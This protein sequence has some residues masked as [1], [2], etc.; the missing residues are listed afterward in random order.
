MA[1]KLKKFICKKCG[2][3]FE[4]R[5]T[6]AKFCSDC[7][8]N[9]QKSKT[10]EFDKL[11]SELVLTEKAIKCNY[12]ETTFFDKIDSKRQ[13]CSDKC[14]S[15]SVGKKLTKR[16]T[17]KFKLQKI[18][19]NCNKP[20]LT[21]NKDSIFCGSKCSVEYSHNNRIHTEKSI[22]CKNC[23][24][25]FLTT[26][27]QEYC[28]IFCWNTSEQHALNHGINSKRIRYN[29]IVFRST[30]E[31]IVAETLDNANF[32]YE[33]EQHKFFISEKLGNYIPDFYI[34]EKDVYIE[35]KGQ[36]LFNAI[37][38]IVEFRKKYP[39]KKLY[40]IDSID[41]FSIMMMLQYLYG[42]SHYDFNSKDENYIES[43][44]KYTCMLLIDEIIEILRE[45]NY[46]D[47]K[48][49]KPID[50]QHLIEEIADGFIF[51]MN[52]LHLMKVDA[53]EFIHLFKQK[54]T[55]NRYRMLFRKT[56]FKSI[57]SFS[58]D[59]KQLKNEN[60]D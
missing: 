26:K 57:A 14:E 29:N 1:Y 60:I 9:R 20:F 19:K 33:Y 39:E 32:R 56:K 59:I 52:L 43:K 12:C 55:L 41:H 10:L 34:P 21:T 35:V 31:A 40:I 3:P 36:W 50:R 4:R 5:K 38:K 8:S 48:D 53:K 51:I 45:T 7:F 22:I 42:L 54:Y 27:N 25:S 13:F 23:G 30:W 49:H 28:N 11:M 24:R 44:V 16:E 37:Q 15:L 47:H 46:K 17:K 6:T 58:E 18:C 2:R